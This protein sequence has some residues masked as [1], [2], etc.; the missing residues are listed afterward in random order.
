LSAVVYSALANALSWNGQQSEAEVEMS[1][2]IAVADK[3]VTD[4]PNDPEVLSAVLQT[5]I[6]ASSVSDETDTERSVLMARKAIVYADKAVAADKADGQAIYN[7]ARANS[8]AGISLANAG[9]LASAVDHLRLA[10]SILSGLIEREPRNVIYQRDL[11]IAY[12][13]MGDA[14]ERR[15]D[16]ADA[17][18]KYQNSAVIFEKIA[19]NDPQNTVA[20]RDLAQSLRSVG[21]SQIAMA[22]LPAAQASLRRAKALLDQLKAEDALG[23]YD[24]QLIDDVETTLRSI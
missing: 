10:E 3:L 4:L 1:R 16:V 18:L 22:Q 19:A 9:Q 17:L 6:L 8:R 2:A 15:H 12:V 21:K 5:Y 13:R 11:A 7:R 23:G 20:R 14:S 24:Q